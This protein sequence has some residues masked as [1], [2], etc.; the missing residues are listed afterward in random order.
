[1]TFSAFVTRVYS[2]IPG[3]HSQTLTQL[4]E[5]TVQQLVE[6]TPR[7][8]SFMESSVE[9]TLPVA[10]PY[11]GEWAG[12]GVGGFPLDI[13]EIDAVYYRYG[14]DTDWET[15]SGPVPIAEI[16]SLWADTPNVQDPLQQMYPSCWAWW[17][18]KLWLPKQGADLP[19]KIDY[20]RDGTRDQAT[21]ARIATNST[22]ETNGWLEEGANALEYAVLAAYYALPTSQ[23]SDQ[24][25]I[26]NAQANA[27]LGNLDTRR[28]LRSGSSFQAPMSF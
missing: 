16:R 5:L 15:L 10:D 6:L 24:V 22:S 1:M 12:A 9:F 19:L 4:R 21:G 17:D 23:N 2:R 27:Y 18:D 25:S 28:R 13:L 7:R 8:V 20:F 26:C 11:L 14:T 3:K